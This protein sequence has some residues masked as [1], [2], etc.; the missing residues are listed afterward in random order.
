MLST[1]LFLYRREMIKYQPSGISSFLCIAEPSPFSFSSG[2]SIIQNI[3]NAAFLLLL[4]FLPNCSCQTF[5]ILPHPKATK[6]E[7]S[8]EKKVS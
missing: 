2:T 8:C 3:D 4:V 7:K 1:L 5:W 6:L